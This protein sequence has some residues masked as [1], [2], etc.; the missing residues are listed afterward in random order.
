MSLPESDSLYISS[1]SFL[2]FLLGGI[3]GAKKQNQ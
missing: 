1:E 2:N 3:G